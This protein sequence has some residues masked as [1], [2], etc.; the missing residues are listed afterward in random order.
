MCEYTW[1]WPLYAIY[2]DPRLSDNARRRPRFPRQRLAGSSERRQTSGWLGS[3]LVQDAS[4]PTAT[5]KN[6]G[7]MRDK[8]SK[9]QGVG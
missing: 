5:N 2:G 6:N 9:G 7:E 1:Q 8:T 4:L 3:R